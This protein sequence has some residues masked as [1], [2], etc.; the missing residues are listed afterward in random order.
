MA[1]NER[2]VPF[3]QAARMLQTGFEWEA[4]L[5]AEMYKELCARLSKEEAREILGKAM[6]RAG[7]QLGREAKALSDMD[8]PLGIAK[9]WDVLYGMGTK[10]AQKL[11]AD[12]FF[13]RVNACAALNVLRRF[14]LSDEDILY[15]GSAYCAG[16]Q[17]HA[18]GFD[19][20]M[21]FQHTSRLMNGDDHC[22]WAFT[23]APQEESPAKVPEEWFNT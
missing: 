10:E 15:V 23:T 4:G 16:D 8:G 20:K 14:G 17:G 22:E 19:E 6:Y 7:V 2:M 12:N 11:D 13:V 18:L 21:A 3:S 1:E 5:F 9:A